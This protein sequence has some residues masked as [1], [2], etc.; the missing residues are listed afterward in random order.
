M[1]IVIIR[2]VWYNGRQVMYTCD[3]ELPGQHEHVESWT[4]FAIMV[5]RR[6]TRATIQLQID[7]Q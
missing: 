6:Q 5:A 3:D 1:P 4:A 7:T 2:I